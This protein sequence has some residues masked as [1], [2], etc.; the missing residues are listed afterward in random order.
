MLYIFSIFWKLPTVSIVAC[1]VSTM[2]AFTQKK[3]QVLGDKLSTSDTV[4]WS[5]R[6]LRLICHYSTVKRSIFMPSYC[7]IQVSLD[8]TFSL[9]HNCKISAVQWP[10]KKK[11][12]S[13]SDSDFLTTTN[14]AQTDKH[15]SL[16]S[17]ICWNFIR[18]KENP[19]CTKF[20]TLVF[21]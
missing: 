12:M 6:Y 5:R 18:K 14:D 10:L 21:K 2:G 15:S 19:S 1:H 4:I 17:L 7:S 8:F 13:K 3:P 16:Q 9:G 20:T 11:N